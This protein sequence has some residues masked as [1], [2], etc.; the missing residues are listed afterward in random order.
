M[1][2]AVYR[3]GKQ[4]LLSYNENID[5]DL[6]EY[7]YSK[8]CLN[9]GELTKL[10]ESQST[11]IQTSI[12]LETGPLMKVGLLRTKKD[13]YLI[14]CIHHLVIDG[15]SW[16]ILL[17][18]IETGYQQYLSNDKIKF[19]EKTSSYKMWSDALEEYSSNH[20]LQQEVAYWRDI[21]NS[22]FE[23]RIYCVNIDEEGMGTV[24]VKLSA[25]DT[26]NLIYH[27]NNAFGTEISDLLLSSL[28]IAIYEMK[29]QQKININ[30][31]GHG[32]ETLHK[33]IDIDRTVGWFTSIY[34]IV[35]ETCG[36]ITKT[37]IRTKEMLRKI[38][39]KGFGY[40]VL[41]YLTNESFSTVEAGITFNFLGS[42]D[43]IQNVKNSF[44][45]IHKYNVDN[46]T[47]GVNI[48]NDVLVIDCAIIGGELDINIRYRK[49]NFKHD[50]AIYLG[51][52]YVS[53]L[54]DIINV[55]VNQETTIKTSSDFGL[56]DDKIS[57][58][59]LETLLREYQ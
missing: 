20:K 34:P 17:E 21:S 11:E 35:V 28:G 43:D 51:N 25:S 23:N 3:N 14:I 1:L 42:F 46:S 2:R 9:E 31:E 13:D 16:R 12:K 55:C 45:R 49:S 58:E 19:S 5:F 6:H 8:S 24:K 52:L 18:D 57:Q 4:E 22:L 15:V 47:I 41:K 40:G 48:Q 26:H 7:D 27:S 50:E 56:S 39:N 44:F 36:N 10:I 30:L 53:A 33:R 29:G 54:K 37:I 32:R 59:D 38:P